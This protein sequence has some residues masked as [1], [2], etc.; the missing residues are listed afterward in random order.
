M[1]ES[2]ALDPWSEAAG[3][4]LAGAGALRRATRRAARQAW[5]AELLP[6]AQSELLRLTARRPGLRVAEAASELL[7]APNTVST[8]VGKLAAQG[9]IERCRS[10]ADGRSLCL[11]L[12][13]AGRKY[14]G[15]WHDLRSELTGRALAGLDERDQQTLTAAA[16]ALRRLAARLEAR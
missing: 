11:R 8:L 1:N 14:L 5:H 9:L 6:S 4:L 13:P 2:E 16:P 7:L 3:Q 10:A 12:T 15:E